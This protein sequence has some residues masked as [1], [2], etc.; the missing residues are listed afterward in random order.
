[1]PR[2]TTGF[3][4][5]PER[6]HCSTAFAN[7]GG[8]HDPGQVHAHI[9]SGLTCNLLELCAA[10]SR[11]G[12]RQ[13]GERGALQGAV[14]ARV[15]GVPARAPGQR[16]AGV[17]QADRRRAAAPH[18]GVRA[19]APVLGRCHL[20]MS[21]PE[22]LRAYLWQRT[23]DMLRHLGGHPSSLVSGMPVGCQRAP[24]AASP[25]P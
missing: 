7:H 22:Q 3:D 10:P 13:G 15:R 19:G 21:T 23:V 8:M 6:N 18:R 5:V 17:P 9:V 14:R 12:G 2:T 25:L 4:R 11:R 20:H 16:R 24:A 1:M